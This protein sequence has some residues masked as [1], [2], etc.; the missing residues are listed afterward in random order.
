[1]W[2]PPAVAGLVLLVLGATYEQRLRDA[3]RLREALGRLG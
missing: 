3:R 1:R 2:A